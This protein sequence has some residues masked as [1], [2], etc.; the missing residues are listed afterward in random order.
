[1]LFPK[2]CDVGQCVDANPMGVQN[3]VDTNIKR[4]RAA[5]ERLEGGY[6]M[7]VRLFTCGP[8]DNRHSTGLRYLL[9]NVR[10]RGRGL[11]HDK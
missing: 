7:S 11:S 8:V 3:R 6:D 1:M 5:L 9:L 2:P 4:I 10:F